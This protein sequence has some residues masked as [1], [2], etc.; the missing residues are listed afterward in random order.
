MF[1][2]W[3]P[4]CLCEDQLFDYPYI[5]IDAMEKSDEIEQILPYL[6]IEILPVFYYQTVGKQRCIEM[7]H[8][9]RNGKRNM[10]EERRKIRHSYA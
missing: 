6:M 4:A 5:Y 10:A 3:S 2:L 9:K 7:K 8:W 1:S